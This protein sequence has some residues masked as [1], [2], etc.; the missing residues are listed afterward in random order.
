MKATN[1]TSTWSPRR[2]SRKERGIELS[3]VTTRDKTGVFDGYIRLVVKT[4]RA[5]PGRSRAP[6]SPTASRASSR[7]RASTSTPRSASTCSTP[8]TRDVPGIIGF[9]AS[10][11]GDERRQH[12]QLPARP[13]K[14]KRQRHRAALCRRTGEPGRARQAHRPP[15]HQ[16][17]QAAGV[18]RGLMFLGTGAG[19]MRRLPEPEGFGG[20]FWFWG[21]TE[22]GSESSISTY[23][24][25]IL[26]RS[27]W[28]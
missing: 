7:S 15:R 8:P 27:L 4:E 28:R 24:G 10:T 23:D 13:R 5:Q 2:S 3:E 17:G 25:T 20:R 19:M 21:V 18:Q 14:G 22:N 6:C 16:A 11:I 12:R 1:P 26:T 9:W